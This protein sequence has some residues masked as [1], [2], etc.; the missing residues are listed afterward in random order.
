MAACFAA[1]S[2]APIAVAVMVIEMTGSVA[3]LPAVM[4]AVAFSALVVG[5]TTIYRSQLRTRSDSPAHRFGFGLPQ[6]AAVPVTTVMSP[7]RL[8]LPAAT[9]ATEAF[10]RLSDAGLPG[11]PVVNTDGAYIG[12][13]H[14]AALTD[15]ADN[16]PRSTVGRL[17]DV[18]AMTLPAEAGLD[19]A[20]DALPASKT[21]WV[22]VLDDDMKVLGI[23][24]TSDLIRGWQHTMQRS[25]QRLARAAATTTMIEGTIDHRSTVTGSP[26]SALALPAGTIVV[27]AIRAGSFMLLDADQHLEVGDAVT[28][29]ARPDQATAVRGALGLSQPIPPDA[30]TR[31]D[32]P[33]EQD[34]P[35]GPTSPPPSTL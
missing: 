6:P 19:A 13:V 3:V 21:N 11:A 29:L 7:P 34:T 30:D 26:I 16:S 12:S 9:T 18:E 23:I 15:L 10:R 33:A 31:P 5:D 24:S 4:V 1:I 28:V 20:I 14:T 27:S 22:P 17:A 8:V 2:H 25:V 35:P 32:A